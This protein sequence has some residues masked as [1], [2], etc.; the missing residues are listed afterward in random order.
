[1][2]ISSQTTTNYKHPQFDPK[3]R[4]NTLILLDHPWFKMHPS[5]HRTGVLREALKGFKV[6]V[7][8]CVHLCVYVCM[9]VWVCVCMFAY[10]YVCVHV[11]MCVCVCL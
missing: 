6:R 2:Y 8:V 5:Q 3:A 1:M 7:C 9:Y 4:P 10:V 11:Y